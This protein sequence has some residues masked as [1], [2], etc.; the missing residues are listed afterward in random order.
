MIISNLVELEAF[1]AL[2]PEER[3]KISE[4]RVQQLK[5]WLPTLDE[6]QLQAFRGFLRQSN[7]QSIDLALNDLGN[8]NDGTFEK[9]CDILNQFKTL[10]S[11]NVGCNHLW[12]L[13]TKNFQLLCNFLQK[14]KALR[15]LNLWGNSLAILENEPYILPLLYNMLSQCKNLEW[16]N[17]GN[18]S[19][20]TLQGPQMLVLGNA[21]AQCTRLQT[22]LISNDP[23]A[24]MSAACFQLLCTSLQNLETF[25][26][27]MSNNTDQERLAQQKNALFMFRSTIFNGHQPP[28]YF[29]SAPAPQTNNEKMVEPYLKKRRFSQGFDSV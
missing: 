29:M 23:H 12:K 16:L 14:S 15:S 24:T 27:M 21:L 2:S 13:S 4:L 22:I 26:N 10:Q 5:D 11:V 28:T 3:A 9:L 25:F 6:K 20:D 17:L 1:L 19:F 18:N 8:F 7:I